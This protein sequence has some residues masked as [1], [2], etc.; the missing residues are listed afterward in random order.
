V[1]TEAGSCSERRL[2]RVVVT[3]GDGDRAPALELEPALDAAGPALGRGVVVDH[4]GSET[5]E[6]EPAGELDRLEVAALLEFR[7]A[8]QAD[9]AWL[10]SLLQVEG[11]RDAD[12]P[13]PC[14]SEPL[15]ISTPGTSA[16]SGW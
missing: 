9:D 10:G 11:E 7:V 1:R 4:D 3:A 14:P 6:R 8:E 13:S 12:C 5:A 2:D 15:E 16:R